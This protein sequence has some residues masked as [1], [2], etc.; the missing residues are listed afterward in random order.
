[1]S[2]SRPWRKSSRSQGNGGNCV[3]A[4][5]GAGG[6]QVRDS[7]LGDDSPILGLAVGD[8]ESLLRAAR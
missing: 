7:K 5:P 1:M 8:F 2:T 6:F 4:R 3:E